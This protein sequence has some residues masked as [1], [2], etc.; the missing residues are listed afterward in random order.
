MNAPMD[1]DE[2]E[3]M[4]LVAPPAATEA[5]QCVLGG[6]MLDNR[7]LDLISD[8]LRTADFYRVDHRLIWETACK[9]IESGKPADV[10]T[11]FEALES[12]KRTEEAGGIVYLNALTQNTPS[13]ANIRGY[14]EAVREA[15]VLRAL[16]QVGHDA[17]Q[18]ATAR[19]HGRSV[20]D[21]LAEVEASLA[22][23]AD[24]GMGA[25]T[26]PP[27]LAET[28]AVVRDDLQTRMENPDQLS[29]LATGLEQIDEK[30]DGLPRGGLVIVAGRAS[31]GKTGFAMQIAQNVALNGG[32][33]QVF[34]M[35]MRRQELVR[36]MIS[37][38]GRIDGEKM[39]RG[40][41]SSQEVA[42][43]E[44][45][46]DQLADCK[47]EIDDRPALTVGQMRARARRL[48]RRLGKIDLVVVDYLQLATSRA[49]Q[50]EQ[51]VS[52]ISRG[53][54]ALARELN[55]PVI[56]LS[57]LN[58]GVEQRADKR[59]MMSDLRESGAIE[60]DADLIALIYRDE[61]YNPDSEDRGLMEVNIGK[62]R[63][64]SVGRVMVGW[65]GEYTRVEN[66]QARYVPPKAPRHGPSR[67]FAEKETI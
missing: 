53:L 31:M 7:A 2:R 42:R 46:R 34:S 30:T 5:E 32:I 45:A 61:Y 20:T 57:Q 49:E 11:V 52:E 37:N 28:M 18:A 9:L 12:E 19:R 56:A 39:K 48:R 15:S 16:L 50:R 59:P 1:I 64:G 43:F 24:S 65:C 29:G 6:L 17:M 14:A 33:V 47:L 21:L 58:R 4:D 55:C 41:L 26:D 22:G 40:R 35:E 36:R 10:I 62:Q 8:R 60:Q 67:S 27:T 66:S 44:H 25:D 54:K 3:A 51:Q 63:D 23:L 13:A 38:V